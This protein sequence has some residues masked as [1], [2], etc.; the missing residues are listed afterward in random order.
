M[1]NGGVG[2][3]DCRSRICSSGRCLEADSCQN[4][5]QD[6]LETG[7]LRASCVPVPSPAGACMPHS[8]CVSLAGSEKNLQ[9]CGS[10]KQQ[11]W[12]AICQWGSSVPTWRLLNSAGAANSP[13]VCGAADSLWGACWCCADWN[14]GGGACLLCGGRMKCQAGRD[15]RTGVCTNGLC[16]LPATCTN[17]RLDPGEGGESLAVRACPSA[18]M[19]VHAARVIHHTTHIWRWQERQ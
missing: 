10:S 15:C 16:A 6:G 18:C 12:P 2:S 11:W 19:G 4:L 8:S 14:C 17:G 7:E 3:W 9:A 1:C 13:R 5:V